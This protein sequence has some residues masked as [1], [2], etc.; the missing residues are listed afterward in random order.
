MRGELIG[1][2]SETWREIWAKLAKHPE[3]GDDLFSDL[4]RGLV[5]EPSAPHPPPP[6]EDYTEDG[7]LARHEDI[8]AA[9][10]Q[11]G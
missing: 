8:D 3:Y 2:W 11:G 6:P 9:G 10:R 1:V 7:E 4:Y 5:P